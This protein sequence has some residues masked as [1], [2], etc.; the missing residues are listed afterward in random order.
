MFWLNLFVAYVQTVDK[1]ISTAPVWA[2]IAA[3]L[4]AIGAGVRRSPRRRPR[5]TDRPDTGGHDADNPSDI[6]DPAT[7]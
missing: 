2:P 4:V 1:V 6:R 5:R 7:S 3:A